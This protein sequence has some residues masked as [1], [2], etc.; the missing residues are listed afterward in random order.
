MLHERLRDAEHSWLPRLIEV[1]AARVVAGLHAKADNL[2]RG[3]EFF[4][5]FVEAKIAATVRRIEV[6]IDGLIG[7]GVESKAAVAAIE[8]GALARRIEAETR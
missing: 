7:L 6:L 5:L 3:E 4:G 2:G 1:Q 8:S